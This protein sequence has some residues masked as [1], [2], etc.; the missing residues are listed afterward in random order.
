GEEPAAAA[1]ALHLITG[2]ALNE[3]AFVPDK[4]DEA[5]LFDEE[6]EAQKAGKAPTGPGGRPAGGMVKRVSQNAEQWKQWWS[7]REDRFNPRVRY[8]FGKPF[9]PALLTDL[10]E[11]DASPPPLRR[12]ALDELAIR[13]GADFPFATDQLVAE[14]RRLLPAIRQWTEANAERFPAGSW[15]F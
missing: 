9:A 4:V 8:R 12:M 14:Q 10:L 3:E 1:E 15:F 13:Y 2:A 6:K 7:A 5:E 11:A